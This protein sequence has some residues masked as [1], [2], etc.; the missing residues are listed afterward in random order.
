[1]IIEVRVA[2]PREGSEVSGIVSIP[3]EEMEGMD[4]SARLVYIDDKASDWIDE[5]I[6]WSWNAIPDLSDESDF[7]R[8]RNL[9]MSF[10]TAIYTAAI[11]TESGKSIFLL[12]K[13][14]ATVSQFVFNNDGEFIEARRG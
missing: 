7:I 13:Q 2:T 4:E 10:N 9:L 14:G 5:H 6:S 11:Y 3:D 1:M 8:L 12:D